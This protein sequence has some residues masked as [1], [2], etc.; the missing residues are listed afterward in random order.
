MGFFSKTPGTKDQITNCLNFLCLAFSDQNAETRVELHEVFLSG[1]NISLHRTDGLTT[2]DAIN[3]MNFVRIMTNGVDVNA[4]LEIL[5]YEHRP[6]KA[7][8]LM[9]EILP[10]NMPMVVMGPLQMVMEEFIAGKEFDQIDMEVF[11]AGPARRLVNVLIKAVEAM[12]VN[13]I[14]EP[15]RHPVDEIMQMSILTGTILQVG[16]GRLSPL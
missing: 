5:D 1:I 13:C 9:C 8:S 14:Q 2:T 10:F 6:T 7:A 15:R 4:N 3:G 11:A 12:N 16:Y